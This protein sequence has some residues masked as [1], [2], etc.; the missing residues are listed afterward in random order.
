M[1]GQIYVAKQTFTT[2][3]DGTP[4]TVHAG[5]TRVREGHALLKGR[6]ELFEPI[7]VQYDVEQATA[8]PGE[9][10]TRAKKSE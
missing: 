3:V 6:S 7:L 4:V 9:K 2:E 8:K 10:R 1:A 5:I